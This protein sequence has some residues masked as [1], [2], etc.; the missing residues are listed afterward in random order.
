MSITLGIYTL[1][2]P[3]IEAGY[4]TARIRVGQDVV[5]I[6][7]SEGEHYITTR[8][9]FRLVWKV[10]G[11]DYTNVIA[12]IEA[13]YGTTVLFTDQF[14]DSWTVKVADWNETPL[15]DNYTFQITATLREVTA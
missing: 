13:A 6:D 12:A 14:G 8:Y 2:N 7:G 9:E 1:S 11:A 4:I 15:K 10:N 3:F 5:Y